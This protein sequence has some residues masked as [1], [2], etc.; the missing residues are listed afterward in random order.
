MQRLLRRVFSRENL[1]ALLL[2]LL[3]VALVIVSADSAPQ[4]IY[5]GF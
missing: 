1:I 4:W 2:C 3:I 5:Q